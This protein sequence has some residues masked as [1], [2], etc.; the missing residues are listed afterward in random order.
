MFYQFLYKFFLKLS[1][2]W[3][4]W[5]SE[6]KWYIGFRWRVRKITCES[7][8]CTSPGNEWSSQYSMATFVFFKAKILMEIDFILISWNS[9]KY[10][11][12]QQNL[13]FNFLEVF[14]FHS[15]TLHQAIYSRLLKI[16]DYMNF[17][18]KVI[19]LRKNAISMNESRRNYY[20]SRTLLKVQKIKKIG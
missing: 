10:L 8:E 12:K 7:N 17:H 2:S 3:I 11:L 19:K 20:V 15:E 13:Y 4:R 6:S 14:W 18:I 9:N 5:M 1:S 16:D